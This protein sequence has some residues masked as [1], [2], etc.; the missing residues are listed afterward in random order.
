MHTFVESRL[1]WTQTL[2]SLVL[3]LETHSCI[4]NLISEKL[5]Y[6]EGD[7]QLWILI[8]LIIVVYMWLPWLHDGNVT[9]IITYIAFSSMITW[10]QKGIDQKRFG[11]TRG[12][13]LLVRSKS[14]VLLM[15]YKFTLQW[16]RLRLLLLNV[17]YDHWKIFFAVTW[18]ILDTRIYTNFLNLS[19]PLTPEETVR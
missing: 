6:S 7:S 12:P 11:L 2:P 17:Q 9:T 16:V 5:E 13:N 4:N 10:L 15:G 8:L 18:K 3:L 19:L 1:Q 14:F